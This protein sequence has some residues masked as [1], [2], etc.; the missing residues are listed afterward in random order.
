MSHKKNG[1][2][3][4]FSFILLAFPN[5]DTHCVIDTSQLTSGVLSL[6]SALR[7]NC[8]TSQPI[9][10]EAQSGQQVSVAMIDATVTS[11][12]EDSARNT[13]PDEVGHVTDI[14]AN[15]SPVR[16]CGGVQRT[17]QVLLSNG[18]SVEMKIKRGLRDPASYVFLVE[19]KLKNNRSLT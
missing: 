14:G 5:I 8:A 18:N 19:G 3:C 2:L 10:I 9:R 7:H 6:P 1:I 13:C 12:M 4:D 16:V 11:E 17:T 15:G